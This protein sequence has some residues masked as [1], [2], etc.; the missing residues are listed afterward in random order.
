M[1]PA[2]FIRAPVMSK[3]M[4][5]WLASSFNPLPPTASSSLPKGMKTEMA[6]LV[7]VPP[8]RLPCTQLRTLGAIQNGQSCLIAIVCN[9]D[10]WLT[11]LISGDLSPSLTSSDP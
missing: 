10:D 5:I 2:T 1:S 9:C 4:R 8:K 11:K 3:P 7:T 6:A